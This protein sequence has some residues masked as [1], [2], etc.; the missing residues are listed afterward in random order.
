MLACYVSAVLR[1]AVEALL[2]KRKIEYYPMKG[3]G[4]FLVNAASGFVLYESPQPRD[5]KVIVASNRVS[6]QGKVRSLER[7]RT[8]NRDRS[9]ALKKEF[10]N[11]CKE[12]KDFNEAISISLEEEERIKTEEEK[13]LAQAVNLSLLEKEQQSQEEKNLS[14]AKEISTR[15][16]IINTMPE[17]EQIRKTLALSKV[18]FDYRRNPDSCV[19]RAIELSR[20]ESQ[21]TDNE[22]LCRFDVSSSN[23]DQDHEDE[24]FLE[25]L[26]L[27]VVDF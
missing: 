10:H 20:K 7:D 9:N 1:G 26:E 3:K 23:Y 25:A 22:T 5:S 16:S 18:E 11:R 12:K 24:A 27:S 17:D 21:E 8:E 15:E 13:L 14:L 6:I 4:S 19:Q 2:R